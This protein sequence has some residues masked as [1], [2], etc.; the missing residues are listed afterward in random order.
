MR[1]STRKFS[2]REAAGFLGQVLQPPLTDLWRIGIF[3][4]DADGAPVGGHAMT[5]IAI[6]PDPDG[7]AGV[8]W[9]RMYDNNHPGE[10][11]SLKIDADADTWEYR[12][13]TNPDAPHALYSG[14]PHDGNP[15]YLTATAPRVGVQPCSYCGRTNVALGDSLLGTTVRV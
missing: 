2:A 7:A 6:E 9:V 15:I 5:P 3:R 13:A 8:W 11:R 12:A 14:S 1:R 4:L 10:E